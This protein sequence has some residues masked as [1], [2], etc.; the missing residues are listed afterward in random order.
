MSQE[1][2]GTPTWQPTVT[3]PVG[4]DPIVETTWNDGFQDLADRT[5]FLRV[6]SGNLHPPVVAVDLGFGVTKFGTQTIDGRVCVP[7]ERVGMIGEA[8]PVDNGIYVV[9]GL[10]WQKAADWADGREIAGDFFNCLEGTD[11][12][13]TWFTVQG[14]SAIAG[15]DPITVGDF[16]RPK[17]HYGDVSGLYYST[18]VNA[19][20]GLPEDGKVTLKLHAESVMDVSDEGLGYD[21]TYRGNVTVST[22]LAT[23]VITHAFSPSAGAITAVLQVDTV[24]TAGVAESHHL[25]QTRSFDSLTAPVLIGTAEVLTKPAS[26]V[27]I[28]SLSWATTSVS[29]VVQRGALANTR[30]ACKLHIFELPKP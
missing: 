26:P 11:N 17:Q 19:A 20:H 21:R 7:G 25:Y 10:A 15:T 16:D 1:L 9:S 27:S 28:V 8:N 6:M 22:G 2:T 29:V 18:Q 4:G 14:P 24:D 3:G 12:A 13:G 30:F 23:T 5:D